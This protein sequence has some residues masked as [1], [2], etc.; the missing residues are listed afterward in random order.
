[1]KGK[2]P[3]MSKECQNQIAKLQKEAKLKRLTHEYMTAHWPC[4]VHAL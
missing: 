1:M 4:L 3:T 2:Q